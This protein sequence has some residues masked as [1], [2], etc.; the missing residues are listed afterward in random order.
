MRR[1]EA[2]LAQ[3]VALRVSEPYRASA[4]STPNSVET[5]DDVANLYLE[6][7]QSEVVGLRWSTSAVYAPMTEEDYDMHRA[8]M[9]NVAHLRT[10][11]VSVNV[12]KT[13]E[14]CSGFGV[15]G[16]GA[17]HAFRTLIHPVLESLTGTPYYP[18]INEV[19]R[20]VYM[21]G[22]LLRDGKPM[23]RETTNDVVNHEGS[24]KIYVPRDAP[25][26]GKELPCSS[27]RVNFKMEYGGNLDRPTAVVKK[28]ELPALK[29]T[30]S[31]T[32][33]TEADATGKFTWRPEA[34]CFC[35][36]GRVSVPG[37]T[38]LVEDVQAGDIVETE[39]GPQAVSY[40]V[41]SDAHRHPVCTIGGRLRVT[42][43]HP[44]K[45]K[46]A[47]VHPKVAAIET[48]ESFSGKLTNLVIDAPPCDV[49]KH[50]VIVDGITCA[51]LG[52]MIDEV[53]AL[54]R[55][56]DEKYGAGFWR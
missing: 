51:T 25:T 1:A 39:A 17:V 28:D 46:G 53:R 35:P 47:W 2:Q 9:R 18:T 32:D 49:H 42:H 40:V 13:W 10:D 19:N 15:Y 48:L 12:E 5:I 54:N 37:G 23:P 20:Q 33:A 16:K 36:G 7:L 6:R 55:R 38:K 14:L 8:D 27:F 30:W 21:G 34:E 24:I 43:K 52:C 4:R 29:L 50:T 45:V 56:M 26:E 22:Q 11:V 3:L 31:V 41:S 44:V